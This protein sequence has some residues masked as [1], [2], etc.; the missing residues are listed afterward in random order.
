MPPTPTLGQRVR[1]PIAVTGALWLLAAVVI[2]IIVGANP[3]HRTVTF[4]IHRAASAWWAQ[5]DLYTGHWGMNYLPQA[6][7]LFSPFEAI[8]HLATAEIV[9]RTS[10]IAMLALGI[11]LLARSLTRQGW[12]GPF[13]WMTV[14]GLWACLGAI[15]NGQPNAQFAAL[16]VLSVAMVLRRRWWAAAAFMALATASKPLGIVM[17]GLAPFVYPRLWVPLIVCTLV[18]LGLPFA[19]GPPEYV[20]SQYVMFATNLT[21]TAA[22]SDHRFADIAG[23]TRTLGFDLPAAFSLPLRALAGMATLAVW[24]V[25]GRRNDEPLRALMLLSFATAY[26]MLFNPMTEANSYVIV[27]PAMAAMAVYLSDFEGRV[28]IGTTIALLVLSIGLLPEPLRR[29]MP[30]FA[31]WWN[32]TAAAVF[33]GLVIYRAFTSGRPHRE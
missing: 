32:P 3:E 5:E 10:S 26:L 7:I 33:A 23:I 2:G 18:M 13:F 12:E 22:V 24:W 19:L 4:T 25:A 6:A 9:Y 8:P 28:R 11:A 17:M 31:L 21:D 1:P 27:A 16:Q 29:L 15:R 30:N 20:V 14:L